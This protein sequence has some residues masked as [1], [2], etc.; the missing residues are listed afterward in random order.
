MG[1]G[2][3]K[4]SPV[5]LELGKENY[6]ALILRHGQWVRWRTAQKCPCCKPNTLQP[7]IHCPKC[8]GLGVTYSYQKDAVVTQTVMI[9]DSSGMVELDA[10]YTDCTM[11]KCYDNSGR[12]YEEATKTGN[13]VM[14]NTPELPVKGVYVT[15]VMVQSV[16]KTLSTSTA[17]KVGGGYFRIR[18]LTSERRRTEG[19]FHTAPGDIVS[20]GKVYDSEGNEYEYEPEEIRQDCIFVKPREVEQIDLETQET[21]IIEIE[22]PEM[23]YVNDI[24]YIPPVLFVILNQN[25]SKSDEQVIQDNN[26]DAVLTFPYEYDVAQDD[27][28]TVLSGTYTLKGVF[29]KKDADYDVIPAYFVGEIVSCIGRERAYIPG[30]DFVLCGANYIKW[31]CYDCPEDGEPYSVTYKVYPTY[32]VVKSIPQ[33]RTSE[34]QRMPKKA[35]IKLY[36]TYGEA[37]GVN[38]K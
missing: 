12:V 34:N 31:L 26:G 32:K 27:V 19:L 22:P 17:D 3:G 14:L 25:L 1:T 9:R 2:L 20:V 38:R 29:T 7:D 30:V 6:E 36:D 28:I 33:I 4:N 24:E 13:F 15:A 16:I 37:R 11:I 23:L 5:Q 21:V 8:K 18:G 35:V 10:E